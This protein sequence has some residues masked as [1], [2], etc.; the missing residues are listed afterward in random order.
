MEIG[1]LTQRELP[2]AVDL[3][4]E[5]GLPV[6]DLRS[7]ALELL[8]VRDA[9]GLAGVA[10]L[11][12]LGEVGLLRSLAVRS[13][14][15]G[16]GLGSALAAAVEELAAEGGIGELFLL[17]T[18]AAKFFARRGYAQRERDGV[19]VAVRDT[20]EFADLCPASAVVMSRRLNSGR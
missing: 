15:R 4:L 9:R 11:E 2:E 5:C 6:A 1:P 7:G 16:T 14:R 3:L 10:G 12:R 8:G 13:D 19:P 17:T 20:R 18:T